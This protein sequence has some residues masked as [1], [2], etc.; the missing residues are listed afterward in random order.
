MSSTGATSCLSV[1]AGYY[2]PYTGQAQY[3]GC[4]AGYICP[5]AGLAT[6]DTCAAGTY[7]GYA[8]TSC[9]ACAAGT[10][11]STAGSSSCAS[12]GATG[13]W[14]DATGLT[15]QDACACDDGW[16]GADCDLEECAHALHAVSLGL[17]LVEAAWP[18]P[19][20]S[21]EGAFLTFSTILRS[22]DLNGDEFLSADEARTALALS[23]LSAPDDVGNRVGNG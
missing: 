16:T 7:S 10:Y 2:Q 22:A 17:L 13:H 11:A 12:C 8:S 5:S 19:R 21:L 9:S 3:Y 14:D 6:Y 18:E 23:Q 20:R 4:P 15:S 1:P